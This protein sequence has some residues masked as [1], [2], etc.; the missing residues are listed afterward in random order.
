MNLFWRHFRQSLKFRLSAL[1]A[2]LVLLTASLLTGITAY[3]SSGALKTVL[4]QKLVSD[5]HQGSDTFCRFR[6]QVRTKL[7]IWNTQPIVQV[8]FNNPALSSISRSGLAAFFKKARDREPWIADILLTDQGN[9]RYED[10]ETPEIRTSGHILTQMRPHVFT[11]IPVTD[12]NIPLILFS[13]PFSVNGIPQPGKFIVLVIAIQQVSENLFAGHASGARRYVTLAVRY[14]DDTVRVLWLSAT[15][16]KLPSGLQSLVSWKSF[17][18]ISDRYLSILLHHK[19]IPGSPVTIVGIASREDIRRPVLHLISVSVIAGVLVCIAGVLIAVV[20]AETI[21][22]PLTALTRKAGSFLLSV[23]NETEECSGSENSGD[24]I[25]VLENVFEIMFRRI[26]SY[27]VTLEEDVSQR[28]QELKLAN[29]RMQKEIEER[30]QAE[31]AAEAANHAK[32]AFLAN[33]SHEL[34]TPLNAILGFS[35]LTSRSRYLL[36]EDKENLDIIFRSGEH[37]L[38]LINDVLDMSKIEAGR[39]VLNEK[40]FDLYRMLNDL[41]EMLR[42]RAEEKSLQLIFERDAAVPQYILTD[43]LKLR[44]ILINLLNN[45]V[46]FTEK[47]GIR[48]LVNSE[49]PAGPKSETR[50]I[51]EVKDTGPGIRS[52]ELESLFEAFVQTETGRQ[53]QEGTGLGL[54]ISRKFVQLMGGDIAVT[55]EV[56][57]GTAFMFDIRVRLAEAFD[58]PQPRPVR[59]VVALKPGQPPVP[60]SDNRRQSG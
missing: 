27:T 33:M 41:E 23:Q 47:D 19:I 35:R 38:N 24:E 48:L 42:M 17:S 10:T 18:D 29:R 12:R 49:P 53:S 1:T 55:S 34:R 52:E 28:T 7:E 58:I 6:E 26:R 60:D 43:E 37:L 56:G 57:H 36:P 46:K 25:R 50:M 11:P 9:I 22:A 21:T 16:W 31:A 39:T 54:P 32:S 3:H 51:F 44:Q 13:H 5:V 20:L 40:S 59:H 30:R 14:S 15:E 4:D 2:G 8:F 45:A